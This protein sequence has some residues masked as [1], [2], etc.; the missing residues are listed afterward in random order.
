MNVGEKVV[1]TE[2]LTA[3]EL[4][5]SKETEFAVADVT[6]TFVIFLSLLFLSQPFLLYFSNF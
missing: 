4:L 5:K 1:T 2:K 6:I 3:Q